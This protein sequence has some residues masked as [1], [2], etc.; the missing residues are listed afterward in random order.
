[1]TFGNSEPNIVTN[2]AVNVKRVA[3]NGNNSGE[4]QANLTI[5]HLQ[6]D[7]ATI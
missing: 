2:N 3:H 1:M 7:K 5:K 6:H 4:R